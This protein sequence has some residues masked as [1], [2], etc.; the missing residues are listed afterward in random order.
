ME[1]PT[2]LPSA[3]WYQLNML[4][5]AIESDNSLNVGVELAKLN[6]KLEGQPEEVVVQANSLADTIL[7]SR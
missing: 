1:I 6:T 5:L 7:Q 2:S 4:Q 3:I